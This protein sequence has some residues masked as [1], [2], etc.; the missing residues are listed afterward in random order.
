MTIFC[1][2]LFL[3]VFF[4]IFQN[5]WI[6]HL[7]WEIENILLAKN[8]RALKMKQPTPKLAC[9]LRSMYSSKLFNHEWE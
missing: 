4:Y 8:Y 5:F 1:N 9:L 7:S 3:L 6:N 2:R